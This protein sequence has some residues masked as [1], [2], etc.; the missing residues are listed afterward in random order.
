MDLVGRVALLR[1]GILPLTQ[2]TKSNGGA[3]SF[4]EH[5]EPR[6]VGGVG[7]GTAVGWRGPAAL[8]RADVHGAY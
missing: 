3:S 2:L 6:C 1:D 8:M 5:T 7:G 4:T